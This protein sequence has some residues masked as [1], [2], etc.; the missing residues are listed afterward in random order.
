MGR[1]ADGL[2]HLLAALDSPGASHEAHSNLL[3]D[4]HYAEGPTREEFFQQHLLWA[5]RWFAA[6]P[7]HRPRAVVPRSRRI[8]L[9]YLTPDLRNHAVAYFFEPLL[10]HHERSRFE[11]VAYASVEHEDA[12]S[13]RM[14][15]HFDAWL[16]VF[17]LAD[18]AL[19][20]RIRDDGI[21]V[22]VDLAGH[23]AGNRLGVFA[24]APAPVQLTYLGYPDTTGLAAV[25]A[26][27]T[28]LRCDPPGSEPFHT[29][30]LLHVPTGMHVYRPPSSAPEPAPPPCAERGHL[31]FG[32]FSNTAKMSERTIARWA[33]ALTVVPTARMLLKFPTLAD[34]ETSARFRAL[35]ERYGVA[36]ERVELRGGTPPLEEHLAA[37]AEVDVMLDTFPYHGTTTT[38]EALWMGVPV[39]TLVGDRHAARVGLSLLDQVG[40]ASF[41]LESEAEWLARVAAL[42]TPEGREELAMLRATLRERMRASS[43]CDGAAK[44]RAIEALY[45]AALK[46]ARARQP[47]RARRG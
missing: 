3:L 12:V 40:L 2:E 33:A 42:D 27:V 17:G 35:F 26:R 9:G 20:A 30:R 19:A 45:L 31:T 21:D 32:S 15:E 4:L 11:L 37:H 43:L 1:T 25:D 13:R 28:D 7:P 39:V 14:R 47:T 16:N 8:R 22:L 10:E 24:R 18:E 23:T 34:R 29:E 46:D 5:Q 38:C 36:A 44:T 6:P 41:A